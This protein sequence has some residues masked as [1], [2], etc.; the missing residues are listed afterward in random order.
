MG[1]SAGGIEA[2][3]RVLPHLAGD[4]PA[5][6]FVVLH[7]AAHSPGHLV[8]ILQRDCKLRVAWA[9]DND[10]IE[11][12]SVYVAPADQ[13]L[14]LE[15]GRMRVVH[16]PK[17][18]R[19][20]P[21]IDPLFRSAAWAFGPRVAGVVLT[22]MLDDGTAGLWAVKSCGG[23]SIVQEPDEA[24]YPEM[25][26]NAIRNLEVDYVLGLE[27][28]GPFLN[29]LARTESANGTPPAKPGNLVPENRFAKMTNHN[30]DMTG[31]GKPS[32][33]T[34]PS[35]QGTLWELEEGGLLRYRCHT[36]HAFAADS[37]LVEQSEAIE[38]ALYS[39]LRALQEKAAMSRRMADRYESRFPLLNAQHQAKATE[40]D[41]SAAIIHRL[42][43]G[44]KT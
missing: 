6:V 41:E 19:H 36:G 17:E 40:L 15:D 39:A 44:R 33:F 14:L 26:S 3:K 21:A 42:L 13:H 4:T 12:G 31:L 35:C 10:P 16:G 1:A 43:S 24:E 27:K 9:Q 25:P 28:I 37:L 7:L 5:A 32:S 22:G 30:G 18:N 8:P 11:Y 20:R 2:L 38:E 29:R 23:I 34:C